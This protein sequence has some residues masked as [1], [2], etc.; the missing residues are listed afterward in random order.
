MI[1]HVQTPLLFCAPL[2]V[3]GVHGDAI[4][5]I[6]GSIKP[7]W[8]SAVGVFVQSGSRSE[9]SAG[10]SSN[11]QLAEFN[12]SRVVPVANKNQTRAYGVLGCVYLGLPAS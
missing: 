11:L 4:R 8:N 1:A 10:G 7:H 12:A 6:T 9:G 5:N 2:G 3:G